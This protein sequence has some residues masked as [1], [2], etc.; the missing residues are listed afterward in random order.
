MADLQLSTLAV[1]TATGDMDPALRF[2]LDRANGQAAYT[3]TFAAAK[4]FDTVAPAIT[5]ADLRRSWVTQTPTYTAVAVLSDTLPALEQVLGQAGAHVV[6]YGSSSEVVDAAWQNRTTLAILPFE[7]LEPRLV[8]LPID[9][10]NPV[11]NANHFDPARYPLVATVYAAVTA[12]DSTLV[13]SRHRRCSPPCRAAIAT[14]P[15]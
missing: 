3:V 5:W 9:G 1:V 15:S 4:R 11:E 13:G 8:V 6:G 12:P 2:T 10:Q 7:Q 14:Q